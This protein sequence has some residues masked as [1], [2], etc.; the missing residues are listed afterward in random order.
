MVTFHGRVK[1]EFLFISLFVFT[2]SI[3]SSSPKNESSLFRQ[4]I[5]ILAV[6]IA[7]LAIINSFGDKSRKK[8]KN[9]ENNDS[10]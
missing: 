5:S 2:F 8:V 4:S 9:L 10:S 1:I 3:P 6:G 7:I